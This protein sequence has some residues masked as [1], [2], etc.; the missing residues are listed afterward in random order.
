MQWPV[1]REALELHLET[2]S[3]V[4]SSSRTA[5]TLADTSI[6]P[7]SEAISSDFGRS[8]TS[9]D[10]AA[11]LELLQTAEWVYDKSGHVVGLPQMLC[12]PELTLACNACKDIIA[13]GYVIGI[14][15]SLANSV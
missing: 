3:V 11:V 14:K 15:Y 12:E 5:T 9:A 8:D 10:N 4:C 1:L 6:L 7:K 2:H 13:K